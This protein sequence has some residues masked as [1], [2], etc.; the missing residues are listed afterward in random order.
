MTARVKA[1]DSAGQPLPVRD[2][3]RLVRWW[4]TLYRHIPGTTATAP[5]PTSG[6]EAVVDVTGCKDPDQARRMINAHLHLLHLEH[7]TLSVHAAAL[8]AP[9]GVGTVLLL[10]GHGAGK[11]LVAT[12]LALAGWIPLAGDVALVRVGDQ[13]AAVVGGTRAF[14]AR[15]APTVRWF[16][17]LPRTDRAVVDLGH[18]WQSPP[19]PP[20]VPV[21][22]AAW[23]RVDGDPHLEGAQAEPMDAHTAHTLWWTSCAHLIDRATPAGCDPLRLLE[24]PELARHRAT[25]ARALA[26]RLAPMVLWGEP[27]AI[28]AALTGLLSDGGD[29]R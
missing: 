13:S 11:T 18:L 26:V 6:T 9:G 14:M 21:R 24:T 22:A 20:S 17:H 25:L 29:G 15:T 19:A 4:P 1:L 7:D 8:A 10:G 28:A 16:P 27:H 5:A 12:A 2:D 23:V 3:G